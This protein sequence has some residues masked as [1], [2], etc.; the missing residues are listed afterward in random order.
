M[1]TFL[2]VRHAVT[3][4]TGNKLSGWMP[5]IHLS[6]RGQQQAD[7]IGRALAKAPLRALYSSPIDR[8]METARAI[9]RH[10]DLKVEK[11]KQL[12]EVQYGTWT[13]RSLKT[14]SRTKLWGTVQRF[15]SAARFPEGETL[16]EVQGRAIAEVDRIR[17]EHVKGMVC[18]VS[19]AD[20]I[21]LVAAHYL[22]VHIDL[23]QRILI[24]PASITAVAIGDLGPMVLA[25]NASNIEHLK[26]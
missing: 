1:T 22:G 13:N 5:G 15:P 10:H 26:G 23:F 3:S 17:E 18:C 19:H 6:D 14:L 9:A 20:V 21:K 16:A 2:F 8:T 4:H 24:S 11:T 7:A 25:V 12:G